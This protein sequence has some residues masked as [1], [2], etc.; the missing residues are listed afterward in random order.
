MKKRVPLLLFPFAVLAGCQ[1]PAKLT[2]AT[3]PVFPLNPGHWQ[4]TQADLTLHS[5]KTDGRK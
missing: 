1:T 2:T 5:S 4:P 3:G